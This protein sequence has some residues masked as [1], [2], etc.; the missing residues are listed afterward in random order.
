MLD[1]V[2]TVDFEPKNNSLVLRAV[3]QVLEFAA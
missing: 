2:T 1:L 3:N